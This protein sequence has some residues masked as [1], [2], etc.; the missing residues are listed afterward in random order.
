MLT[1]SQKAKNYAK[2]AFLALDH[3]NKITKYSLI[4]TAFLTI[5]GLTSVKMANL[6]IAIAVSEGVEIAF[7]WLNSLV[8]TRE[9]KAA[10]PTIAGGIAIKA[11]I[12]GLQ[13][14]DPANLFSIIFASLGVPAAIKFLDGDIGTLLK[15]GRWLNET[16]ITHP[17]S[18][19]VISGYHGPNTS[20]TRGA[21]QTVRAEAKKAAIVD[22]LK[23][24]GI[25]AGALGVFLGLETLCQKDASG[26]PINCNPKDDIRYLIA[27]AAGVFFLTAIG[28]YEFP[29]VQKAVNS[30]GSKIGGFGKFFTSCCAS[31]GLYERPA[32]AAISR[33][34][35]SHYSEETS[36]LLS[37]RAEPV[38]ASV[39]SSDASDDRL[40]LN[41]D[42]ADDEEAGEKAAHAATSSK[43]VIL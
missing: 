11:C 42:I 43:C 1:T 34:T 15:S 18:D 38:S 33:P 17:N 5:P 27:G 30:I 7:A 32:A 10:V 39:S 35:A 25:T 21:L 40:S 19:S 26:D 4:G 13:G 2:T 8:I 37:G 31:V 16:R 28:V 20:I 6:F 23:L 14:G 22:F 24:S 41:A 29:P 9:M 12:T 3:A 36:S